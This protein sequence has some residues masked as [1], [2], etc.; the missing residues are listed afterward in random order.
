MGIQSNSEGYPVQEIINSIQDE[1]VRRALTKLMGAASALTDSSG[2][3]AS[4][5]IVAMTN[6]TALTDNGGGTADGT[7]GAQATFAASTPWDGAST[8]PSAADEAALT[9]IALAIR[10]NLK[11]VTTQLALQRTLNTALINAVASLAAAV[12]SRA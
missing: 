12:N 3:T 4:A 1:S 2:G 11:E 7:V 5:T 10:N 8:Y 6:T 9:A